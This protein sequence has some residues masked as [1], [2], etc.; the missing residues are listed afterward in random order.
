MAKKTKKTLAKKNAPRPDAQI[1]PKEEADN[2]KTPEEQDLDKSGAGS[3]APSE[4][5]DGQAGEQNSNV[6]KDLAT[7]IQ[8][9]SDKIKNV[10]T[11]AELEELTPLVQST[12]GE[13]IPEAIQVLATEKGSELE[14]A[15]SV[16]PEK[17]APSADPQEWKHV[18]VEEKDKAE[19]EGRLIGYNGRTGFALI[20]E[21]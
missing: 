6:G 17:R 7:E 3:Q 9:V 12:F 18:T 8:F 21:V 13:E 1:D 15:E 4:K 19:K 16:I 20:R 11:M 5:E 14:G 10:K 2:V